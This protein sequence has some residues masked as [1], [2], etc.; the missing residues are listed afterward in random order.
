MKLPLAGPR[1][2]YLCV[3]RGTIR[4]PPPP[5]VSARRRL[6]FCCL[7]ETRWKGGSAKMLEGRDGA[8]YKFFWSGS[9]EGVSG[10]GI[11]VAERWIE[12][13]IEVRRVSQR[14]LV[15]RVPTR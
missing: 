10:V 11:L 15:V 14:L 4:W 8:R 2:C 3:V 1:F 6:D 13:V 7:Q 5:D 9:E 12:S